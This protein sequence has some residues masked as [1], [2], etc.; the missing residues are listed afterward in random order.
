MKKR[1]ITIFFL[2]FTFSVLTS[3]RAYAASYNQSYPFPEIDIPSFYDLCYS[4]YPSYIFYN[5]YDNTFYLVCTDRKVGSY[6]VFDSQQ[7]KI[8]LFAPTATTYYSVYTYSADSSD[9]S[10]TTKVVPGKVSYYDNSSVDICQYDSYESNAVV[11]YVSV[12]N[13][14]LYFTEA[15]EYIHFYTSQNYTEDSSITQYFAQYYNPLSGHYLNNDPYYDENS[16]G[17]TTIVNV[18][19]TETNNLLSKIFSKL[20]DINDYLIDPVNLEISNIKTNVSSILNNLL[21]IKGL[22][23]SIDLKLD[24]LNSNLISFKDMF[25]VGGSFRDYLDE[26]TLMLY[27]AIMYGTTD[28]SEAEETKTQLE[29]FSSTANGLTDNIKSTS[30]YIADSGKSA[31][32]YISVFGDFFNKTIALQGITAIIELGLAII[33]LKKLIGR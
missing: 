29:E 32:L 30:S 21:T 15:D 24:T 1:K 11:V 13:S 26:K 28:A 14:V 5:S 27:N 16:G 3:F 23:N 19:L 4:G 9:T 2:V 31:A 12:N 18:D 33:F 7:C 17:S 6:L 22:I 25:D 10:W 20:D 8:S